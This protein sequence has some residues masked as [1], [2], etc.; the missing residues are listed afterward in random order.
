MTTTDDELL[1]EAQ[2]DIGDVDE[3]EL[4]LWSWGISGEPVSWAD[5]RQQPVITVI[6]QNNTGFANLMAVQAMLDAV[7]GEGTYA[8]ANVALAHAPTAAFLI[9]EGDPSDDYLATIRVDL[10]DD[11]ELALPDSSVVWNF[12]D[13]S[14]SVGDL[15]GMEH[16]YT[17]EGTYTVSC[18]VPV[19]GVIFTTSQQYTVGEETPPPPPPPPADP[20]PE[21][22]PAHPERS[23]IDAIKTWVDANAHAAADVLVH[24]QARG[25]QARSTLVS[26]L[27]GFI[28]EHDG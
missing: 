28:A 24:E 18:T 11:E 1:P 12:G 20:E 4:V 27:E 5:S 9:Q 17:A 23:T 22:L 10:T 16:G 26:W 13:G 14:P 2:V 7:Y 25:A 6:R 15:H 21:D 3:T 8:A 19:A